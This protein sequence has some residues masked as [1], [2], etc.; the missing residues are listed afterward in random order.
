MALLAIA[1][2][3]PYLSILRNGLVADDEMQVLHNPYTRSFHYL[4]KIFTTWATGYFP[5]TP[6]YYRPLMNIG[7][8]L[9]YQVFGFRIF[10]YHLA[11]LVLHAAVVCAVFL[12]TKRL[13]QSRDLALVAAAL[14]AIH[15]VHTEAV[16]PIER[17]RDPLKRSGVTRYCG[18]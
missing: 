4:P 3:L 2:A 6:D 5:G 14:F 13:F 11:N 15:P 7:Y 8:L 17:K 18:F 1:S 16:A 9:C 12:L 10:G